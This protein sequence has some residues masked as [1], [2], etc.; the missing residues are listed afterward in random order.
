MMTLQQLF[1]ETKR[2]L[3]NDLAST[4]NKI[5]YLYDKYLKILVRQRVILTKAKN[6][7]NRLY[8]D[9]HEY[10]SGKKTAQEYK[11]KPFD[12]KVLKGDLS[13][14]LDADEDLAE[15]K[16]GLEHEKAKV[17]FLEQTLKNLNNK[18]FA[19]KNYIEWEKFQNGIT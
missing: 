3:E 14:Y 7:Y 9:K 8:K 16:E 11:E 13:I 2:D 17:E 18:S 10:Y 5:P 1:A 15:M 12:I 19:F 4:N 6:I